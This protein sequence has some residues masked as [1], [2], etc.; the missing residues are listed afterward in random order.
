MSEAMEVLEGITEVVFNG[1]MKDSAIVR[2]IRTLIE[3]SGLVDT[4][5]EDEDE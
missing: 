4:D 1:D 3:D 2:T 5:D